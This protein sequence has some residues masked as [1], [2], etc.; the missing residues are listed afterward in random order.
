MADKQI[1]FIERIKQNPLLFTIMGFVLYFFI[2]EVEVFTGISWLTV[3]IFAFVLTLVPLVWI[4]Y[5]KI[6]GKK[7]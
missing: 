3:G 1:S 4:I 2:D 7:K 6:T 5:D